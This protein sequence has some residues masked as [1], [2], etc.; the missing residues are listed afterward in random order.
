MDLTLSI[1]DL[2]GLLTGIGIAWAI[3]QWGIAR[4]RRRRESRPTPI[5]ELRQT[6][7]DRHESVRKAAATEYRSQRNGG[8][9]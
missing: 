8:A 9:R 1:G 4:W 6:I 3:S 7:H 5:E 2:L